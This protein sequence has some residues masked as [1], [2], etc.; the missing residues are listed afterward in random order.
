[1]LITLPASCHSW[2]HVQDWFEQRNSCGRLLQLRSRLKRD[3]PLSQQDSVL[4][5]QLTAHAQE[6][7]AW[8]R[9][10]HTAAQLGLLHPDQ[11]LRLCTALL[12]HR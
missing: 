1:M 9:N 6:H 5:K 11:L 2:P 8:H 10:A 12:C 3:M 4:L 7:E